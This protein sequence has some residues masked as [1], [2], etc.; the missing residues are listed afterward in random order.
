MSSDGI[1]LFNGS[2]KTRA[3]DRSTDLG[4][5]GTPCEREGLDTMLVWVGYMRVRL[6]VMLVR[7]VFSILDMLKSNTTTY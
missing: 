2:S 7:S 6:Y 4:I 3:D 1:T 5:L